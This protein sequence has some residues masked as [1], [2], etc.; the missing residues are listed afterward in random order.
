MSEKDLIQRE[1]KQVAHAL[2]SVFFKKKSGQTVE[3]ICE[4]NQVYPKLFGLDLQLIHSLSAIHLKALLRENA[5]IKFLADV[6]SEHALLY[7]SSGNFQEAEFYRK[8]V[9]QLA[10][11]HAEGRC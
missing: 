2:A 11:L 5:K 10:K 8:K 9:S 7:E 4:I 3:A 6:L 1:I